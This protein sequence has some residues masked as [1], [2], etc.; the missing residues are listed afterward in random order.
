MVNGGR[1]I[2]DLQ[3]ERKQNTHTTRVTESATGR[4]SQGERDGTETMSNLL[5][6]PPS[7]STCLKKALDIT[8]TEMRVKSLV[9]R[10]MISF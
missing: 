7:R 5:A 8:G 9:R 3:E 2:P 4:Q 1:P 10:Q 6:P